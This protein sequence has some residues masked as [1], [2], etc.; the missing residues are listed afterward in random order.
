MARKSRTHIVNDNVQSDTPGGEFA[1]RHLTKQEFGRRLHRM[2]LERGWSQSELG[3]RSGV[4]KASISSYVLGAAYP[5]QSNLHKMARAFGV[6]NDDLLPNHTENA[7]SED[8]P[9]FEFKV[10]TADPSRAWVRLNRLMTMETA[11]EIA[12]LVTKDAANRK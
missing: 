6:K 9:D 3:R 7:I 8:E 10:S 11:V 1:P 5:T 2:L 12:N 4:L